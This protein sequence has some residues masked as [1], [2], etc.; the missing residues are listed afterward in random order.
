MATPTATR[1]DVYTAVSDKI[2][3]ALDS[4]NIPW[5]KPWIGGQEELP[6]NAVSGRHYNGINVWLLSVSGYSDPRWL[7][8][9]QATEAGGN[10]KKGE[11]SSL[12]VFWRFIY[13]EDGDGNEKKIP[14]LRYFNVFNVEQCENLEEKKLKARRTREARVT[15]NPIDA[16]EAIA[17]GYKDGPRVNFSGGDRAFYS[18]KLDA[19]TLPKREQFTGS[20]ELYST[21]FHELGHSTG[22]EKRLNRK[23]IVEFDHFGSDKY[24]KEELVAEFAS[25][26]LCAIAGIDN[27]LD[28]STAYIT[29]WKRAIRADNHLVVY[30]AAQAQHAA[31]HI[32]GKHEEEVSE[33]A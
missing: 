10:V 22:H 30:A 13:K 33:D 24:G 8:Y 6:Y 28:N 21:L 25:A 27:T 12:I 9:K 5:R 31:D 19:I 2:V 7:T 15:C 20:E 23:G 26:Y 16:A 32:L 14:L 29:N 18:P 1:F 4:G 17:N 11:K 3:A